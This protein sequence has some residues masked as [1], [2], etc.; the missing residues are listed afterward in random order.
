MSVITNITA[1]NQ[2]ENIY[3]NSTQKFKI[4]DLNPKGT[5]YY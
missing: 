3:I 5:M 4:L 2:Y 1:K